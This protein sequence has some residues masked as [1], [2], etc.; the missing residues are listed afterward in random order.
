MNKYKPWFFI[1]VLLAAVMTYLAFFGFA[2]PNSSYGPTIKGAD[3]MRFGIDIRGGVSATFEAKDLDRDPTDA[4]L[5]TARA[6]IETRMDAKNILDREVT[7]D[8]NNNWIIVNFPW[9]SDETDFNPQSAVAELGETAKLTFRDT[10]GNV[11]MDGSHVTS[12]TYTTDTSGTTPNYMVLLEFD[13]EGQTQFAAAT[14]LLLNKTMSIY[15]DETLISA[16]TVETEIDSD[17]AVIENISTLAAAKSLAEKISAGALPFSLSA[18]SYSVI[19]PTL[20]NGALDVMVKAGLLAFLII[21]VLLIVIYRVPGVV[22][23]IALIIQITGQLLALS[24]PQFTL[25]LPGIASVIL[26]IGL[27][28][29]ANVIISE[30]IREELRNGHTLDRAISLG[31]HRAFSSVFDGNITVL[32]VAIV[33]WVFGSGTMMSFAYSLITGIIFNFVAGAGATRL[34]I[35]SLSRFTPFRKRSQYVLGEVKK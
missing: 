16:P 9:K 29:D 33:L 21:C 35:L 19:S 17:S 5:D 12:A 34:M 31:F 27:G 1:I 25:T 15:M 11:V 4:E 14:K 18:K 7:V 23:C 8:Y 10:E 32:I 22:A 6:I 30:R 26:S 20:G 3:N 24:I 13:S 2:L 28:V